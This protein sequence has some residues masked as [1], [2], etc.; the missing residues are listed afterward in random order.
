MYV[1]IVPV[2]YRQMFLHYEIE[3]AMLHN[4][5]EIQLLK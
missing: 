3:L 2:D 4:L 1:L 5:I